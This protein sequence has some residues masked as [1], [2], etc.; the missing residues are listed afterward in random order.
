MSE[1]TISIHCTGRVSRHK[2]EVAIRCIARQLGFDC[3]GPTHVVEF[4]EDAVTVVQVI[5]Q[6]HIAVST[7]PEHNY[8]HVVVCSCS[9]VSKERAA[10][11]VEKLLGC[12]VIRVDVI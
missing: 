7:W 9:Y 1:Q 2:V 10:E 12:E 8:I 3:R 5:S 6:S 4:G 11:L